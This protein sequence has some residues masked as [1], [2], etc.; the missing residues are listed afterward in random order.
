MKYE[1]RHYVKSGIK[2]IHI[3]LEKASVMDIRKHFDPEIVIKQCRIG[4][5]NYSKK[6]C[7]P[8]HS[9]LFNKLS[10]GFDSVVILCMYLYTEEFGHVTNKYLRI[11][12]ANMVLKSLSNKLSRKIESELNG[13]ALLNG[14]CNICKPCNLKK[15]LPC[16]KTAQ[17]RYSME[18][19]GLN[20]DS[21]LRD[22]LKFNLQ[23]YNPGYMPVYT[24][25]A[26]C[27]LYNKKP[28]SSYS[29]NP[30]DLTLSVRQFSEIVR[31]SCC[32]RPSGDFAF[33][34]SDIST[35]APSIDV[36]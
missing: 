1:Y 26:S 14:S 2:N 27:V 6:W 11:R 3:L 16:K 21:L 20:V 32:D 10:K 24:S 9:E 28:R 18:A 8:P 12:A 34:S 5:I 17:R 33:S 30:N 15:E 7:C 36:R 23:W 22:I 31:T 19:T 13:Y 35:S 4:C 25:V 29:S